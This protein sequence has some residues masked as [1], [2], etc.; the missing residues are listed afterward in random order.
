MRASP[1]AGGNPCAVRRHPACALMGGYPYTS[2]APPS[3]PRLRQEI[4]YLAGTPTP[5]T[6]S[7][8]DIHTLLPAAPTPPAPSQGDTIPRRHPHP[9]RAFGKGYPYALCRQPP[10]HPRL[11][12][13]EIATRFYRHPHPA[14]AFMRDTHTLRRHPPPHPRLRR[15]EIATRF[16]RHP[17][18]ACA[19]GAPP[20]PR[21]GAGAVLAISGEQPYPGYSRWKAVSGSFPPIPWHWTVGI[22]PLG[23]R[24]TG[25]GNLFPLPCLSRLQ[26]SYPSTG[27]PPILLCRHPHPPGGVR[28][29]DTWW[30]AVSGVEPAGNRIRLFS[31]ISPCCGPCGYRHGG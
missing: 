17:H 24:L 18:P 23:E 25:R 7:A 12:R 20:P 19:C 2:P 28:A 6:P 13:Q 8:G 21:P 10:P 27:R 3:R 14:R 9:A 5:P 16:C 4:P 29:C 11:R 30:A 1:P 31:R 15:Q 22:S 26:P